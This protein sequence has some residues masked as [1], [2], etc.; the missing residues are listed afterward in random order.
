LRPLPEIV[1]M[2]PS[3]EAELNR[4]L[5]LGLSLETLSAVRYPRDTVP[6][7]NFEEVIDSSLR[8]AARQPWAVGR[9][10][11]LRQGEDVTLIVYGSLVENAMTAAQSLADEGISATVI[12]ARFCKPIDGEM[13]KAALRPGHAVLTIE[14]HSLQN[15]FGSAVLEYAVAHQLPTRH[16]TRLGHPDRL[17]AHANR[18]EQL[19]E[20]GLDAAGI[21]RSVKDAVRD[22]KSCAEVGETQLV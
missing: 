15:G 2:A 20:V 7:Q 3:D 4:A 5:K 21:V 10:R 14:D 12:D 13:I 16:L 19:A 18:K 22:A 9:S 6:A 17:I 8:P 1:L 11:T